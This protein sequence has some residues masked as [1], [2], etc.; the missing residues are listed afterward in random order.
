M[1][2]RKYMSEREM[3]EKHINLD[4]MC[5]SEEEKKEVMG[6]LCKYK[7]AFTY[8]RQNRYMPQHRGRN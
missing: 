7:E 4:N 5:L 8:E 1:D 6:M 3:L 2:E